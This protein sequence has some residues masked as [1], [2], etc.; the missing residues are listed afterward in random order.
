MSEM[1]IIEHVFTPEEA[2]RILETK[3]PS[4]RRLSQATVR[5]YVADMLCGNWQLNPDSIKFAANGDLLDGQHRLAACVQSGVP[6]EA[7]VTYGASKELM[8]VLDSGRKRSAAD[9]LKIKGVKNYTKVSTLARAVVAYE[10]CNGSLEA[11]ISN[12]TMATTSVTNT[13]I[14]RR[15]ESDKLI[16]QCVTAAINLN[17]LKQWGVTERLSGFLL[18]EF[19]K[20]TDFETAKTF[21]AE[22]NSITK[23]EPEG[24]P[25]LSARTALS[26]L[27]MRCKA[28]PPARIVGAIV[29]KAWNKWIK[30]EQCK[31]ITFRAGGATPEAFPSIEHPLFY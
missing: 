12:S 22:L 8:E 29:I 6:L 1:K 13:R 30:G 25:I 7:I 11:V 4:N 23:A 18:Y 27:R 24:S 14:I 5:G 31:L 21:M 9:L 3:N 20:S 2:K 16:G 26:N 10:E 28:N 19:S 15:A 17:N